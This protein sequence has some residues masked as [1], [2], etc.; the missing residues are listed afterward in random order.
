[1]CMYICVRVCVCENKKP[2]SEVGRGYLYMHPTAKNKTWWRGLRNS[3]L[4]NIWL[5]QLGG[6]VVP[7]FITD[8]EMMSSF[9]FYL[10]NKSL[11]YYFYF[12]FCTFLPFGNC[13]SVSL[14]LSYRERS[15]EIIRNHLIYKLSKIIEVSKVWPPVLKSEEIQFTW[16]S[17]HLKS[18][19]KWINNFNI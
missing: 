8:F 1:M 3:V 13:F 18:L 12:F 9:H 19:N 6:F 7:L 15:Y 14:S 5:E 11:H 4:H 16:K 2:I 17:L 10:V